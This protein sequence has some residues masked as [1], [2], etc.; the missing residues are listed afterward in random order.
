VSS[1]HQAAGSVSLLVGLPESWTADLSRSGTDLRQQRV[2]SW[3]ESTDV[4]KGIRTDGSTVGTAV[5]AA[6]AAPRATSLNDSQD[7]LE[8]AVSA[9]VLV[10][11]RLL[12]ALL[13]EMIA[14]KSGR[15]VLVTMDPASQ[16]R[17]EEAAVRA[18]VRGIVTYFESLRPAL[19]KRG[20]VVGTL[21]VSS[22][23][24]DLANSAGSADTISA[25]IRQCL[26][27]G[28]PQRILKVG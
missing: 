25:A 6:I 19:R 8:A 5:L 3:E 12:S 16:S 13:P 23:N 11:Q 15:L 28:T 17:P 24:A 7:A 9:N 10:P 22:R 20:V 18:S 27:N 1:N 26:R 14:R 21:L 4:L 2:A